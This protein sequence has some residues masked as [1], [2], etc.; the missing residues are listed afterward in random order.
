MKKKQVI[1]ILG[2]PTIESIFEF[3]TYYYISLIEQKFTNIT[4][5]K[6]FKLKFNINN[7]LIEIA[8]KHLLLKE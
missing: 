3:N 7:F 6:I 1:N 4:I 5:K 2:D 8:Y